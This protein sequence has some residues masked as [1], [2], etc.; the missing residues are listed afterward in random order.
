MY[1]NSVEPELMADYTE[2][3]LSVIGV[4]AERKTTKQGH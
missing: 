2:E 4:A 1:F 3:H